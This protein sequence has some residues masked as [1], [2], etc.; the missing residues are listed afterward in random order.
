M[1]YWLAYVRYRLSSGRWPSRLQRLY[2]QS[3][4]TGEVR[5]ISDAIL[6]ELREE[7]Q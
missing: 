3:D 4:P 1:R 5:R 2:M 7:N 6:K